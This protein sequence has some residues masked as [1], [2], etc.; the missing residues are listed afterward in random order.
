MSITTIF[1][2]LMCAGVAAVV[3]YVHATKDLA[4]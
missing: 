1:L 4:T 3:A 2:S